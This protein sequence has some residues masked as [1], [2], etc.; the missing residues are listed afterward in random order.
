[1]GCVLLQSDNPLEKGKR[2]YH[3]KVSRLL[4]QIYKYVSTSHAIGI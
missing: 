1:M 3:Q 4:R 2:V